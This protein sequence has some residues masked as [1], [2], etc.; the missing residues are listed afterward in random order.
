MFFW[1]IV[2]KDQD[3]MIA[4]LQQKDKLLVFFI[5]RWISAHLQP[6]KPWPADKVVEEVDQVGM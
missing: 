5:F 3:K 6:S 1:S 2:A 4:L